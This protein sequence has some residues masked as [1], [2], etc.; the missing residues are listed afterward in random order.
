VIILE[1]NPRTTETHKQEQQ[2]HRSEKIKKKVEE[3]I[4]AIE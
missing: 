1:K 2:Q 4:F 3:D